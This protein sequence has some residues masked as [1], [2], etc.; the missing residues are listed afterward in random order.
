MCC[1]ETAVMSIGS[2]KSGLKV[3]K[4]HKIILFISKRK[5]NSYKK[6]IRTK[7]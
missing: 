3:Y 6:I 4:G 5:N 2:I 7:N 1:L